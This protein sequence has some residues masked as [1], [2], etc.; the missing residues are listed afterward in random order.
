MK[1][2]IFVKKGRQ[3]GDKFGDEHGQIECAQYEKFRRKLE[4]L[5]NPVKSADEQEH[6]G[7]QRP[8]HEPPADQIGESAG[9]IGAVV[10]IKPDGKINQK[11][12]G[13]GKKEK[14]KP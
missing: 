7:N 3:I 9:R 8:E 11:R 2:V 5:Q 13:R 14:R 12:D 1:P 10:K 6:E 4:P